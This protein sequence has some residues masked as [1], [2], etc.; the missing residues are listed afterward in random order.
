MIRSS[1]LISAAATDGG[2]GFAGRVRRQV[3]WPW[4]SHQ[5]VR[6]VSL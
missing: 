4:A 3:R 1:R 2:P 6:R 5:G